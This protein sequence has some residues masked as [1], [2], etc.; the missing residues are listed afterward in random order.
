MRAARRLFLVSLSM[1]L[2]AIAARAERKVRRQAARK[3][4]RLGGEVLEQI[5]CG[6]QYAMAN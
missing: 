1:P 5:P 4:A 6:L 3:L 2:A